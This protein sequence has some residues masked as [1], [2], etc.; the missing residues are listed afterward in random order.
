MFAVRCT[1]KLLD[2]GAPRLL[3]K[4]VPPTTVLGDW[5]ANIVVTRPEHLVV[6]ISER[7]LLP[8]IVT[9]KDVKQ[10]P[11]RLATAVKTMLAAVGVSEED[12]AAEGLEMG[13]GYLATTED[14]RVL[15]CLNDFVV[16]FKHGAGSD[17]DLNVQERALRLARMPCSRLGFAFP[18]E[19]TVAAF[20][21]RR[22]IKAASNA[23]A[24]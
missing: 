19:A 22:A 2:R 8:V 12:V 11:E 6:C 15:G 17:P 14:R 24:A 9:A 3:T 7:T 5:Y 4:P 21:T 10:L 18:S 13:A 1:R 23:S 16:H 20:A